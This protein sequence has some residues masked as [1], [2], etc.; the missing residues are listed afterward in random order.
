MTKKQELYQV[1]GTVPVDVFL[2]LRR[3]RE[4]MDEFFS[5]PLDLDMISKVACLSPFHF[6]RSFRRAFGE[7][8]HQYLTRRR[9][10]RAQELL[11]LGSRSV[12]DICYDVGYESP[13]SFSTLFRQIT[14]NSP[15]S[16]RSRFSVTFPA[17]I[18]GCFM[19][20][21]GIRTPIL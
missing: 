12:T 21:W 8:P 15:M 10:D 13:G 11:L 17:K 4:F 16:F 5:E 2:R 6:L 1:S 7:T 19:R 9:I 14:G 18:P 3:A 20:M